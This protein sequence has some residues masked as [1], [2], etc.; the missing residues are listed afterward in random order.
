MSELEI[1]RS[2]AL[3]AIS[4]VLANTKANPTISVHELNVLALGIAEELV[5]NGATIG[6]HV[7]SQGRGK[8]QLRQRFYEA[9][10]QVFS[11]ILGDRLLDLTRPEDK[12]VDEVL[13]SYL[14]DADETDSYPSE[15]KDN[16]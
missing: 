7:M 14:T 16:A 3:T 15:D 10:A 2:E 6:E 13:P 12:I 5:E 1:K 9:K 8:P 11:D 4:T